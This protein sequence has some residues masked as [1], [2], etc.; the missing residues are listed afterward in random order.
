V[1]TASITVTLM[2]EVVSTFEISVILYETTLY[3]VLDDRHFHTQH[4]KNLKISHTVITFPFCLCLE[5]FVKRTHIN[6]LFYL[7]LPSVLFSREFLPPGESTMSCNK[8]YCDTKP[9]LKI[10]P[11]NTETSSILRHVPLCESLICEL[12]YTLLKEES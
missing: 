7:R 11:T 4:S 12:H 6:L 10:L 1:L 9:L 8:C 2:M 3:D 5:Y